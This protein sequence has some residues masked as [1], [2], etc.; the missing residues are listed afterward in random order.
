MP[1]IVLATWRIFSPLF[2]KQLW[3]GRTIIPN[4]QMME[5]NPR[6]K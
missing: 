3:A 4:L 2:L 1:G 6:A 5:R